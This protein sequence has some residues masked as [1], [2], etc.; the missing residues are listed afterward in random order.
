MFLNHGN[1]NKYLIFLDVGHNYPS[2]PFPNEELTGL[3]LMKANMV[4]V[5]MC[6][7]DL[8]NILK[9]QIIFL[10]K[11]ELEHRNHVIN[12]LILDQINKY[13]NIRSK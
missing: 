2:P 1:F 3:L 13:A 7:K 8:I 12:T 10:R 4:K 5:E 9:E 6:D 11:E